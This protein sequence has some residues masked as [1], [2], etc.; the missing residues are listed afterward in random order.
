V[1]PAFSIIAF[2]T[3]SGAGYGL[4][5]VAAVAALAGGGGGAPWAVV[6][7]LAFALIALGLV[8]SVHH[9]GRPE[10]AWRALSQ[11][12]SSWLSREAVAALASF[13]AG[14][15]FAA[16]ALAGGSRPAIVVLAALTALA[17]LATVVATA[18][19]YASLRPIPAWHNRWVVPAY[20]AYA[21]A[22][23]ALLATATLR[24]FA[25]PAQ[26]TG[27][28]AA[29]ALVLCAAIKCAYWR[30]LDAAHPVATAESATGLGAF[31]EV[32]LLDAPHTA[33]N[34]VTREMG[35]RVVRAHARALRRAVLWAGLV[36]PLALV[37]ADLAL[38]GAVALAAA[39][40][41]LALAGAVVERWLFFAEARHVVSL[42][43][44]ARRV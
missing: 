31:G 39:A 8:A 23:G 6:L 41:L 20:L 26:L 36:L 2:T 42:Y 10:R 34:Y 14:L 12:R 35:F 9:L 29:A 28:V 38:G 44:G 13:A 7:G 19:I 16:L 24:A 5:T 1:Y 17:A 27:W 43:Y 40:A 33:A 30:Q 32:R 11:W 3:L 21:A 22:T 25:V 37:V 4:L 18:M 15:P